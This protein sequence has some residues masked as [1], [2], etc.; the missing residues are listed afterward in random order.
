MK[1]LKFISC[2]VIVILTACHPLQIAQV[3]VKHVDISSKSGIDSSL[4]FLVNQYKAQLDDQMNVVL[5][6]APEDMSLNK[7]SSNLGNMMADII[8]NF[9][10]QEDSID[11]A[12]TN[13]GGIR[14][15]SF[16][17]GPL[18]V[19]DA[20]QLMPFE[21]E[22]VYIQIS[23]KTVVQ[24]LQHVCTLGGW[25]I[26]NASVVM[27]SAEIIQKITI[28]DKAIIEDKI[29]K[30][31]TN[32]Y[33]ANGG[34]KCSFLIGAPIKKSGKLF[35]DAII[36]TWKSQREGIKVENEMRIRYEN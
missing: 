36:D 27:D 26:S 9:Y 3:E 11:F 7:P 6:S 34:D 33:I 22:I 5:S 21:N 2:I 14:A 28:N 29:Y 16:T 20:Y 19:R 35:R 8:Y 10:L 24:L 13:F 30:V 12:I 15:G 32:D 25:P 17:K 31:A 1:C 4:Y 23:G 18:T